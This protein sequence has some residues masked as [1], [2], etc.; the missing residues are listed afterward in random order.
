MNVA[1]P[2]STK[3]GE[4]SIVNSCGQVEKRIANVQDSYLSIATHDL[5]NGLY[6]LVFNG[7]DR[8]L[9]GKFKVSK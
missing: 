8:K 6:L 3:N 4:L 9:I 7:E 1:L 5:A 2:V